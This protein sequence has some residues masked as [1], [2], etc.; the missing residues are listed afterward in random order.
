[1]LLLR[2]CHKFEV[3]IVLERRDSLADQI[4]EHVKEQSIMNFKINI[5]IAYTSVF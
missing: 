5:N 1:M 4:S 3:V 2:N